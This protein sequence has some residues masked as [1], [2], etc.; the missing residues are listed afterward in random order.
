MSQGLQYRARLRR[1]PVR[2]E[3]TIIRADGVSQSV[4]LEDVSRDGCCVKGSLPIGE[5]VSIIL[6]GLGRRH[7]LVRWSVLGKAGLRFEPVM[8]GAAS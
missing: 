3:A 2:A 6:P 7:A 8:A 1:H 4:S 5:E